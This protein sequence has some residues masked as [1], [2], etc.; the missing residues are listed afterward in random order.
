MRIV[1]LSLVDTNALA[2][3]CVHAPIKD[4]AVSHAGA[5]HSEAAPMRLS[6]HDKHIGAA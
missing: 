1:P 2:R 5:L 3:K 6:L 4:L